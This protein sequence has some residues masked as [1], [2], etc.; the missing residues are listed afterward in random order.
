M[1]H[2]AYVIDGK[3]YCI[4]TAYGRDGDYLYLHGSVKSQMLKAA[5]AG[6]P[7]AISITQ[8]DGIV[9]A[10][11][12]FNS[13]MNYHSVVLYGNPEEITDNSQKNWALEVVSESIWPGRWKE[14]RVPTEN[15]L[16]ATGVVRIKIEEGAAKIRTGAPSDAKEDYQTD[17]WA[18]VI[19]IHTS[20][21]APVPDEVLDKDIAIPESVK[22]AY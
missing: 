9:L 22:A 1:C 10:R 17:I 20:F 5:C 4:P 21:G 8:V 18:G 13:S 3:P 2:V 15:E 16:K 7:L 12:L 6:T 19:P 14:A 11:S